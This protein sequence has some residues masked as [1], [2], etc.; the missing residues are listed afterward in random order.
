M[1]LYPPPVCLY[2]SFIIFLFESCKIIWNF[3]FKS[4]APR[5]CQKSS[6]QSTLYILFCKINY[7]ID[8]LCHFN[9]YCYTSS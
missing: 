2:F 7:V 8:Y 9:I 3:T 1:I 6:F 4:S 5:L